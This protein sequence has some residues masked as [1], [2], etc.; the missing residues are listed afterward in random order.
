MKR[1]VIVLLA[2]MTITSA[3]GQDDTG[4]TKKHEIF[5]KGYFGTSWIILPKVFLIN[6]DAS[7]VGIVPPK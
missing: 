2:I 1:L 4:R 5:L 7:V 6:P 3:F